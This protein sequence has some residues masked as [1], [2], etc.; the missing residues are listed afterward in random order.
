MK[1]VFLLMVL[2]LIPVALF[3]Q[4]NGAETDIFQRT[5]NF[6]IFVAILWYLLA[7]RAREFFANRTLEIQSKLD[8]VQE[9]LEASQ[10]KVLQAD[11]KIE[12]AKVISEEIIVS[13]KADVESIKENVSAAVDAEINHLYKNLE[14]ANKVAISK[15]KKEVV[16]E[17]LE[18]LLTLKE[19]Q[20]TQDELSNIVLKKVS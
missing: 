9:A 12:E 5:V 10:E 17:V 20:L 7:D 15:A 3:A 6:I 19:A 1:K 13:A 14:E 8:K 11:K 2:A 16:D 18:E 4:E